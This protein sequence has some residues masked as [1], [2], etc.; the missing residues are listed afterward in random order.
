MENAFRV[1]KA[2]SM[3]ADKEKKAHS[4]NSPYYGATEAPAGPVCEGRR[5]ASQETWPNRQRGQGPER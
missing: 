1:S 4:A 5:K 2:N 3:G